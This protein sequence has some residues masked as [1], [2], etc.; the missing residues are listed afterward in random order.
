MM[1]KTLHKSYPVLG[2]LITSFLVKSRLS[3]R[4]HKNSNL[5][6]RYAVEAKLARLQKWSI[7][8]EAIFAQT[9]LCLSK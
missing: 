1:E 2:R 3:N 6:D 8:F 7:I 9:C 4:P 5:C